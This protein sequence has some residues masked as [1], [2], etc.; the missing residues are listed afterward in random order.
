MF[1]R[2]AV[3]IPEIQDFKINKFCSNLFLIFT[4]KISYT[5]NIHMLEFFFK[6]HVFRKNV[7][8]P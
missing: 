3:V 4:L 6:R 7:Y 5:Q 2:L 8:K 1:P